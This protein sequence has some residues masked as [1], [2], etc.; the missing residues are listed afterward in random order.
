LLYTGGVFNTYMIGFYMKYVG[1]NIFFNRLMK[2]TASMIARMAGSMLDWYFNLRIA[3]LISIAFVT[4]SPT[5]L[6]I[7]NEDD[8]K[9]SWV[10]MLC[11]FATVFGISSCM[12]LSYTSTAKVFPSLFLASALAF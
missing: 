3:W 8:P 7:I 2:G 6:F 5:P 9:N 4:L 1:G 11:V 10:V 12:V